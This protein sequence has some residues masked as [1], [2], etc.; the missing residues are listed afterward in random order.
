MLKTYLIY[1]KYNDTTDR[2]RPSAAVILCHDI[3]YYQAL[4]K[5]KQRNNI[6]TW[7]NFTLPP[8]RTKMGPQ[9]SIFLMT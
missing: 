9:K 5:Y 7:E 2:I 6:E 1:R 3:H 8:S 4:F